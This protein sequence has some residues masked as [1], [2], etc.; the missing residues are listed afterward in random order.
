MTACCERAV[1]RPG[2][3]STRNR[4]AEVNSGRSADLLTR[5]RWGRSEPLN[6]SLELVCPTGWVVERRPPGAIP[7]SESGLIRLPPFVCDFDTTWDS[8]I[9][10]RMEADG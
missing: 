8:K 10:G 6:I 4:L 5:S 3:I 2:Q 1:V 9:D 7:I